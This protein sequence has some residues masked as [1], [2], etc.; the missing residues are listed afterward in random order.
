MSQ[1]YLQFVHLRIYQLVPAQPHIVLET[2]QVKLARLMQPVNQRYDPL[3]DL[4][5]YH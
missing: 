4:R 1:T 3:Q 2:Q 5:I